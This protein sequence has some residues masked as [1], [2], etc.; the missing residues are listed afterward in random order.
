MLKQHG[1]SASSFQ[2]LESG[3]QF[4]FDG[5]DAFVGYV[6]TGSAWV[7]AGAPVAPLHRVAE[8]A[9]NFREAARQRRRRV[10]FFAAEEPFVPMHGWTELRVG[11][12]PT[13]EPARWQK[14]VGEV[15]SL[16][17]QIRRAQHKGVVVRRVQSSEL[18]A[19]QPLRTAMQNVADAWIGARHMAPMGFLVGIEPFAHAEEKRVWVAETNGKLVA[20]L[21]AVPIYARDGWLLEDLLRVKNA[22]NGTVESLIDAAML[23]FAASGAQL[24]T[25]GMAPLSGEIPRGLRWIRE[26]AKPL[27]D[28]GGVYAFKNK[29]RPDGWEPLY[30][31]TPNEQTRARALLESIRAFARGSVASFALQTFVRGPPY[32]LTALVLLLAVWIPFLAL[33]PVDPWFPS[34]IVK[35]SWIVFDLLLVVL[36]ISL[37]RGY[38]RW[39]G[40]LCAALVTTDATLTFVEGIVHNLPR[41]H[42]WGPLVLTIV[43]CAGPFLCANALWGLVRTQKEIVVRTRA[44]ARHT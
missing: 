2:I 11:E 10:C 14:T 21:S 16:R 13:W 23:D 38:R 5:D 1:Q 12:Q 29:L 35:A 40:I 31:L 33:V 4:Y 34:A 9:E 37:A 6:D 39:L 36:L 25:M 32:V 44:A 19:G 41:I 26:L 42:S 15:S 27:Y 18:A 17:A 22:P 3:F 24:V 30:V 28:F 8:V 43:A 20:F 7:A